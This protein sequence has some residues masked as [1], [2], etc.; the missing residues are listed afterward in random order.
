MSD[1]K[2][3][4]A[5][6][7]QRMADRMAPPAWQCWHCLSTDPAKPGRCNCFTCGTDTAIGWVHGPCGFCEG[8]IKQAAL[9][10]MLEHYNI[11]PREARHW[12]FRGQ[13]R[14]QPHWVFLPV[15]P[16]EDY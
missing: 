14:D 11:D 6:V 16:G 15:F 2:K 10:A 8:R 5:P 1:P 3:R 9:I 13:K 4:I 12:K 7:G